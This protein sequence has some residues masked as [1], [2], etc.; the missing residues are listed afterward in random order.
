MNEF[1]SN[2]EIAE[3]EPEQVEAL[4]RTAQALSRLATKPGDE[5]ESTL[6]LLRDQQTHDVVKRDFDLLDAPIPPQS[7]TD[8]FP[9]APDSPFVDFRV[10]VFDVIPEEFRTDYVMSRQEEQEAERQEDPEQD[11]DSFFGAVPISTIVI[12]RNAHLEPRGPLDPDG[13]TNLTIHTD[14]VFITIDE[15]IPD[16]CRLRARIS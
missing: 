13:T 1:Q 14:R 7:I 15:E 5:A 2:A 8:L 12:S 10:N 4:Y 16:V 9:T 11:P 3:A 6:E